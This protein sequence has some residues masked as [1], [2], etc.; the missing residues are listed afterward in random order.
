[1]T[2]FRSD[3]SWSEYVKKKIFK[4]KVE[5]VKKASEI[6]VTAIKNLKL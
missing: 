1:M 5:L 3:L 2:N 6:K 4:K